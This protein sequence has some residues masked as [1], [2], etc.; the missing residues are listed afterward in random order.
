MTYFS[1]KKCNVIFITDCAKSYVL[2]ISSN[3]IAIENPHE[4]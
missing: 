1:N 3:V 2:K 4:I